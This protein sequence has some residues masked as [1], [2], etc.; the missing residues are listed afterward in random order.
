MR[1]NRCP[2]CRSGNHLLPL[3]NGIKKPHYA[4]HKEDPNYINKKCETILTRGHNKGSPC[5]KNCHLGFN[6]CMVH[7]KQ[8]LNK[9]MKSKKQIES[10]T[11]KT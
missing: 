10:N 5:G 9:Q 8:Q 11:N 6:S 3:I 4:I 2:Y 7:L 1:T